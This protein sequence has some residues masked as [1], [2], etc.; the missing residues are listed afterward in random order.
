M[1]ATNPNKET[2]DQSIDSV[3][4]E[5]MDH[6]EIAWDIILPEH[7]ESNSSTKNTSTRVPVIIPHFGVVTNKTT[8][9]NPI[10]ESFKIYWQRFIDQSMPLYMYD[11][12]LLNISH[13][14]PTHKLVTEDPVQIIFLFL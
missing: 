2:I 7:R 4:D 6:G 5:P 9:D 11:G 3:E 1:L 10:V 12:Q 8:I 14:F 13:L